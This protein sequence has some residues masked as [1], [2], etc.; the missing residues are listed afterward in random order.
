MPERDGNG[1]W[2]RGVS[3]N[4]GGRSTDARL[5]IGRARELTPDAIE[6]LWRLAIDEKV[7]PAVRK[8]CYIAILDRGLGRPR[9][10]VH[11]DAAGL[12]RTEEALEELSDEELRALIQA[13]RAALPAGT[14]GDE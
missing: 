8:D 7:T 10:T 2:V 11:L 13:P 4:P 9:Q 14:D 3:G 12:T 1:R 6:G 5:A